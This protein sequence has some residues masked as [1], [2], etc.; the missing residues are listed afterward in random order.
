MLK[1]PR[2]EEGKKEKET[3]GRRKKGKKAKKEGMEEEINKERTEKGI[4]LG[5]IL[6]KKKEV[7]KK[8]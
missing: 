3:E 8:K 2:E 4:E 6:G 1:F 7:C 5:G